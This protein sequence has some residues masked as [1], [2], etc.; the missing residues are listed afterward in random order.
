MIA[1]FH[2]ASARYV[3]DSSFAELI[4]DLKR[5]SPEFDRLWLQQHETPG[6][7]EGFKEVEHAYMGHLEFDHITDIVRYVIKFLS[8]SRNRK[9]AAT[10]AQI[11]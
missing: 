6:S 4:E 11:N 9:R 10:A 1:E 8:L 2:T 7:L 5:V 3:E